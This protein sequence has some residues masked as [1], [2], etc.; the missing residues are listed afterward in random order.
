MASEA[1]QALN[2][3]LADFDEL[4]HARNRICPRGAGKPARKRGA[5]VLRGATV[6]LAASF[7]AYVEELYES[8]VEG[9]YASLSTEERRL[10]IAHTSGRLNNADVHKINL[11]YFNLG[12]PWIMS[13][14]RIRWQKCSNRS[15][16]AK[17]NRL[18]ETRG[19]IAHGRSSPW[20]RKTV[21]ENWRDVVTRVADRLDSIVGT[22]VFDRTGTQ[23][24]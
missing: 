4:L 13:D 12:I 22:Y 15:V 17:L 14:T 3:R 19:S 24:W 8:A 6:L 20:V 11:L 21:V 23:P 18:I 16:R 2:R 7:E 1:R 10:L 5:A 9:I